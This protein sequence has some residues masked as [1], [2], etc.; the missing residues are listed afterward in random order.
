M[1]LSSSYL[2]GVLTE[3]KSFQLFQGYSLEQLE[4][5]CLGAEVLVCKHRERLYE[6][7]EVAHRFGIVLS[8][9]FKLSRSTPAGEDAIMHFSPPGDVVAAFIMAQ[10]QPRYP[11]SVIAMGPSRFLSIPRQTY[12]DTWK[13]D[14]ELISRIQ[15]LLSTRMNQFY[16]QKA[17]QKAPLSARIAEFLLNFSDKSTADEFDIRIPL[18]RKEIADALGVTVESVIRIM[19][20]WSKNSFIQTT[21][22]FITVLRPDKLL[23]FMQIE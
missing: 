2:Q 13:K 6:F 16:S 14:I 9:A 21:E 17:M 15:N 8:G 20:D 23:E 11:V 18:T 3:I 5:H 19:S 12:L 22:Q 4:K 7:G 1:K 10:P